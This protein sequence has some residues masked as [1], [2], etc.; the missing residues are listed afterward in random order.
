MYAGSDR[1]YEYKINLDIIPAPRLVVVYLGK[2]KRKFTE[3]KYYARCAHRVPEGH[4]GCLNPSEI[5][6]NF[7]EESYLKLSSKGIG[8]FARQRMW[9][10]KHSRR[11]RASGM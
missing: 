8:E 5:R 4:R 3:V 2:Q 6:G 7:L 10:R 11:R 1:C 9:R